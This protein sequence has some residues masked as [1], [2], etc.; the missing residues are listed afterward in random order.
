M[1]RRRV[2]TEAFGKRFVLPAELELFFRPSRY[3]VNDFFRNGWPQRV[4]APSSPLILD[5]IQFVYQAAGC[6]GATLAS[7]RGGASRLQS[8]HATAGAIFVAI[9]I[10]A[11]VF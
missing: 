6:C 2:H 1:A 7:K 11:I 4:L 3:R 8:L 10:L 9:R 5:R